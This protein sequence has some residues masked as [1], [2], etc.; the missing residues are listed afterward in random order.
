MQFCD[1]PQRAPPAVLMV[2]SK[3][4]SDNRLW[5][6]EG[7][8]QLNLSLQP[9]S[10]VGV[11]LCMSVR[12]HLAV[13]Q[14]ETLALVHFFFTVAMWL[15]DTQTMRFRCAC[16]WHAGQRGAAWQCLTLRRLR[17]GDQHHGGSTD[18]LGGGL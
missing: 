14:R 9:W 16:C 7:Q 4:R 18:D 17:A 2:H 11:W 1:D 5:S 10:A 3:L 13:N 12:V 6:V 8:E 15:D